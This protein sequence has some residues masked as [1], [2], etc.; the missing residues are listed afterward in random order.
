MSK[1]ADLAWKRA[2]AD[3]KRATWKDGKL[4]RTAADVRDARPAVQ[5][6]IFSQR[7]ASLIERMARLAGNTTWRDPSLVPTGGT[8]EPWADWLNCACVWLRSHRD[9]AA[10]VT[11]DILHGVAVM[12]MPEAVE[13]RVVDAFAEALADRY[14][15]F[16]HLRRSAPS[17]IDGIARAI[18]RTCVY[19][20]PH[21]MPP[22][23]TRAQVGCAQAFGTAFYWEQVDAGIR[24]AKEALEGM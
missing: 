8:S 18:S 6:D 2:D 21:P 22:R 5:V 23:V 24:R 4:G 17:R 3:F 7:R 12:W 1:I 15:V 16:S 10:D 11:G 20:I 13:D 19:G 14:G 9:N